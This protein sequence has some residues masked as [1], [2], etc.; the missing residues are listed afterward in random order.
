LSKAGERPEGSQQPMTEDEREALADVA[1]EPGVRAGR[2]AEAPAQPEQQHRRR[3]VPRG[4]GDHRRGDA[5]AH[6][7]PG[8]RAAQ[9]VVGDRLRRDDPAVRGTETFTADEHRQDRLAGGVGDH[10]RDAEEHDTEVERRQA[11]ARGQRERG[12][13]RQHDDAQ[14]HGRQQQPPA[15]VAVGE[16]TRRQR[17]QQPRG[18]GQRRDE[19]DLPR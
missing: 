10:L 13:G 3:E 1:D 4:R 19:R 9:E 11:D 15:V 2:R 5:D 12:Q 8:E 17:D 7:E 14:H 16:G 18:G 6:E